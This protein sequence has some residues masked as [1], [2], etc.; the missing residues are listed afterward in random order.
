MNRVRKTQPIYCGGPSVTQ[1]SFKELCDINNV[2]ARY[3]DLGG[4]PVPALPPRYLDLSTAPADYQSALNTVIA[5]RGHFDALPARVRQR[6][7]GDP[8]AFL[9]FVGNPENRPELVA[10]GLAPQ[11]EGNP[12][13]PPTNSSPEGKQPG[14]APLSEAG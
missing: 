13:P 6:F 7:S 11:I 10:M 12:T 1:Q 2:V 5:V 4:I 14:K 3:R 8:V 9:E